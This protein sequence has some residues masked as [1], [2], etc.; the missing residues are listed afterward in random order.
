MKKNYQ[1]MNIF[2][3]SDEVYQPK[4]QEYLLCVEFV[5]LQLQYLYQVVLEQCL[6]IPKHHILNKGQA[7]V[8]YA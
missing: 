8:K 2:F 6:E 4:N 5:D 1:K 7:I 3:D